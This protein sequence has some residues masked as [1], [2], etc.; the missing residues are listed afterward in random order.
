MTFR[1]VRSVELRK[2]I[3]KLNAFFFLIQLWHF[4]IEMFSAVLVAVGL[5]RVRER[6]ASRI[7]SMGLRKAELGAWTLPLS[8]VSAV[9]PS[10]PR[11]QL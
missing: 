1:I 4:K 8:E 10:G 6:V 9:K 7:S 2:R 3:S 11:G 5:G